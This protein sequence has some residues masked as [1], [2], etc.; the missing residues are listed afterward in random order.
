MWW[1]QS[2]EGILTIYD[3]WN[4]IVDTFGNTGFLIVWEDCIFVDTDG[5]FQL[6][7]NNSR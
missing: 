2:F 1:V 6:I 4:L 3:G 5:E 7:Q